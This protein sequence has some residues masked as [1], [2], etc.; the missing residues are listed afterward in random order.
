MNKKIYLIENLMAHHWGGAIN[1]NNINYECFKMWHWERSKFYFYNKHYNKIIIFFI[2]LKSSF[3]FSLKVIL[4]YFFDKDKNKIFRS[5][6][7][8]LL[9]FYLNRKKILTLK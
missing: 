6:L 3:K 4:Y 2:A 9:S 1:D 5:R 8:G 7:N